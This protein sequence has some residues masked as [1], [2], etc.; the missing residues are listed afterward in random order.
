M[1]IGATEF[2]TVPINSCNNRSL[3][4][5]YTG[6]G[7]RSGTPKETHKTGWNA[8]PSIVKNNGTPNN[9][10][11]RSPFSTLSNQ[12]G[13]KSL[14]ALNLNKQSSVGKKRSARMGA[15]AAALANPEQN[16]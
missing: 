11:I 7:S 1:T 12:N 14:S 2:A 3:G 9:A 13:L 10:E 4:R 16:K 6:N 5:I 15:M 8:A